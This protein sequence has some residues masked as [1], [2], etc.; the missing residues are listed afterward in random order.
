MRTLN[1]ELCICRDRS[2]LGQ[3]YM[4][5]EVV[6]KKIRDL[7]PDQSDLALKKELEKS[8]GKRH[9]R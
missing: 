9:T 7:N 4:L 1:E 8:S 5:Q 6:E 2:I 3:L